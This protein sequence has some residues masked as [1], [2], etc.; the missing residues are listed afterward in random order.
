MMHPH[1]CAAGAPGRPKPGRI[2]L[3]DRRTYPLDEGLS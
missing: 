1:C 3:G 2:P